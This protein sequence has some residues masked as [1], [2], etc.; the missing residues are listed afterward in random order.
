MKK[1]KVA[2]TG[3]IGSG[4]SSFCNFLEEMNYPVVKADEAARYLMQNDERIKAKI[5]KVFGDSAYNKNEI[6][7]KYISQKIFNDVQALDT[8]N[9]IVHPPTIKRVIGLMDEAL[10]EKNIVFHEA[11]LIYEA[12]MDSLFDYVVLIKAD[13]EKRLNRAVNNYK[14]SKEQFI[15]RESSQIPESEKAKLADFVFINN[16]SL[17][18]LKAKAILLIKILQSIQ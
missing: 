8:M 11:A 9:S 16:G 1:L 17:D 13:Y 12:K 5:I 2:I 14:F 18:E 6:N 10:K 15:S 3:N 7:T 4:K